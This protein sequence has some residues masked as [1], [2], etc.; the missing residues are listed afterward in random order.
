MVFDI[1]GCGLL[2]RKGWI[3]ILDLDWMLGG[4][5]E[6]PRANFEGREMGKREALSLTC[7][8]SVF[9][10]HCELRSTAEV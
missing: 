10:L 2:K 4:M 6:V 9:V 1:N 3:S 5:A 8:Q 7:N